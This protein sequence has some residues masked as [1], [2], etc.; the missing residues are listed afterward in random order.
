[1]KCVICHSP[2][3]EERNVEETIQINS[4]IIVVPV[5]ALVCLNC[6]ERY[7]DRRT[8]QRLEQIEQDVRNQKIPLQTVGAVFKPSTPVA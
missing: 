6:S 8:M 4:D 7:Y 2:E 3:I 1:M 5:R